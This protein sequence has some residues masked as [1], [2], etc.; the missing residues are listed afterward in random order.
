M[1]CVFLLAAFVAGCIGDGEGKKAGNRSGA[2]DTARFTTSAPEQRTG[3]TIDT[4]TMS[5]P[6]ADSVL[7]V[8]HT[9]TISTT[10]GDI[11]IEL[12]GR[13][14]PKTVENFVGL[15]RKKFFEKIGFHRAVK[16][17]SA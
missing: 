2:I 11:V 16:P 15:A 3:S 12:Y 5:Q 14:A 7:V 4:S 8:T 13:D 10:V 9:A 17:G 1:L 6:A